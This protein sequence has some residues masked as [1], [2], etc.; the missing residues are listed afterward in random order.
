MYQVVQSG[1]KWGITMFMGEYNHNLD[2]K[3]RLVIPSS[4]RHD[5]GDKFIIT[6]GMEKCLYIYSK[7]EW[8][9]LVDKFTTLPFTRVIILFLVVY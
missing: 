9:K 4:F 7:D 8:D 2:D 6:K 1:R 3:S 5:L